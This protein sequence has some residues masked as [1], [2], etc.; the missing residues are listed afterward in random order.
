MGR[1][2][3]WIAVYTGITMALPRPH[4]EMKMNAHL[5]VRAEGCAKP[6]SKHEGREEC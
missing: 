4:K 6:L 3:G 5:S 2:R 1:R